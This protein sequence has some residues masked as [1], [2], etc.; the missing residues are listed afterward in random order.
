MPA[1]ILRS[2]NEEEKSFTTEISSLYFLRLNADYLEKYINMYI[3]Y[4]AVVFEIGMEETG[5]YFEDDL[6]ISSI[7]NYDSY[8]FY[9]LKGSIDGKVFEYENY[10]ENFK[11]ENDL[12][13]L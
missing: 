2:L 9:L 6:V 4:L 10:E 13:K 11:E 3:K 8:L 1:N 12:W 7:I 5:E